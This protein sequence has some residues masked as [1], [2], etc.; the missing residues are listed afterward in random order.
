MS[1]NDPFFPNSLQFYRVQD[2]TTCQVLYTHPS[3]L[4]LTT[5]SP[6]LQWGTRATVNRAGSRAE[7]RP[8]NI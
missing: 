4:N 8:L 3:N 6:H 1:K 2:L 7:I 5:T